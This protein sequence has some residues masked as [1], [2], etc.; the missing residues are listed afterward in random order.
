MEKHDAIRFLC[1]ECVFDPAL[2]QDAAEKLWQNYR[3]TVEAEPPR[4]ADAP[5]RLPL[6]L[7]E[8]RAV[9]S[10]LMHHRRSGATNIRDVLKINPMS[11]VVHQLWVVRDRAQNYRTEDASAWINRCL[12]IQPSTSQQLHIRSAP[13]V[14]DAELP[15]AEFVFGFDPRM[16]FQVIELARHVSLTAFDDRM[17][18]WAGYHRSYARARMAPDAMECSLLAV[19]TTDGDFALSPDSPNQG[20][21][22]ML[23]GERPPLFRDFFDDRFFMSVRL[24]K[25]RFQLQIRAQ[26]VGINVD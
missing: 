12:G 14:V 11:L 4:R 7:E 18:L 1:N 8:D 10:F 23:R 6:N 24:R 19:L 21:R 5:P 13:N 15:H 16:G 9:Q 3:I 26:V 2:S 25:K 17:L 22:E 20:L